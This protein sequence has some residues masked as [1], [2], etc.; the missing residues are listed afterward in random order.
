M[1]TTTHDWLHQEPAPGHRLLTYRGDT[2]NFTLTL[3]RALNGTA[4]LRTNIGYARITRNEIFRDVELDD[5]PL[6]R[7]WFD[8][9]MVRVDDHRFRIT[10]PLCEVGHFEAK[11]FFL[12]DGQ[13]HP[14]WPSGSNTEVNVEP[15]ATCCANIIYNAFVRQFGPNRS[16]SF[17]APVAPSDIRALD[18]AG[19]TVIPPSGTFRDLVAELDFIIGT[20]GCRF[21]QL[22]PIH[23]TP[24]TYGRMGR[25]GSPYAALS[26][27][28]VDPALARFDPAATPLEQFIELVDA[29]HARNAKILI[30]IAINHTGWA[31]GLHESHP[32]WLVRNNKGEIEVPGAWGVR[33]EDLTKLDYRH[34]D[35]WQYM[36]E[37]FLTWCRRGVDGFRCDAGYM[38]PEAA[39]TYI[40][41]R[42]REQFPDTIFL[43]E[44]LGGKISV[45]RRLLNRSNFNWAYSELF[46][47][48]DRKQIEHYL[49]ETLDLS[50]CDGVAVHYAETHDNP[51]LASRSPIYARMRTTLS[52]LLS[53]QGAFG[54]ANGVEWLAAEKINVHEASS[55]SWG[56]EPNQVAQIR[57]LSALLRTHPVFSHGT[58][59][60][61]I[62]QG[63]GNQVV[64]LRRHRPSGARLLI[65]VNLDD[66]RKVTAAWDAPAAGLGGPDLVDLLTGQPVTVTVANGRQSLLLEPGQ[67]LCLSDTD[68]DLGAIRDAPS[69]FFEMPERV[70]HQMLCAKA[71]DVYTHYFG[72]RHLDAF[73]PDAAAEGLHS[74]PEAF[75]RAVNPHSQESRVVTWQYPRD[76]RRE[77]MVPPGHFLLVRADRHFH[78]RITDD[79]RTLA[80]EESL[81]DA[82]GSHFALFAPPTEPAAVRV[83]HLQLV[84]H[85]S[86]RSRHVNGTLLFLPDAHGMRIKRL[87]RRRELLRAPFL[88]L[89]TNGRGAML[90]AAI[91]WGSLN[92]RYD[93]LLAANLSDDYPEDRRVLLTRCR[94]WLIYQGFS[95][96]VGDSCLTDF[97]VDADNAGSWHFHIPTGQGESVA[98]TLRAAMVPGRNAVRLVFHRPA[99]DGIP[100]RLAD[101]NPVQLILRPDIE[102]RNFHQT[103]KAYQ[104]P[105]GTWPAAVTPEADGFRFSPG[106]GVSLHLR[107]TDGHYQPEPEWH[108]MVH[109]PLEAERGLDPDSDLFSPGY[110][111][112]RLTGG[113]T[114][115]LS[116]DVGAAGNEAQTAAVAVPVAAD[117]LRD[118]AAALDAALSH[119][120]V[121]RGQLKSVVAGF[122]W[123]LDWGRDALI[124]TR[125]LIAAGRLAEARDVLQQFGRFEA[126]GT[127]PN[128]I[129]GED[130]GNR[131]TSD[132]PL[133]FFVACRDLVQKI[134]DAGFLDS[135]WNGRTPRDILLSMGC[136]LV[137]GTPNG[138]YMDPDSALLFSPAHF[139]WMD[140]DHPA[141][142]PREGFPIEIQA[143]W[144]AALGFLA[145]IDPADGGRRWDEL[146]TR[147]RRSII[148][149]YYRRQDGYFCD[150]LHAASGTP[151]RQ[152]DADDALRPNQLLALT[153]GAVADEEVGRRVL[154]ACESLLVPGAIRSLD[155]RPV[156]RPLP[157][158]LNGKVLNDAHHPYQGTYTGDE[159]T[160]RKVAYHNGTAWTWLFPSHCEAWFLFYGDGGRKAALD[161]LASGLRL[162]ESGCIGHIPEILDGNAPHRQR[163]CDAQAWGVSELLRVW[164]LLNEGGGE[165]STA[166]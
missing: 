153:L 17:N 89:A 76:V 145:A 24:T 85:M 61:L 72:V 73:D 125:G 94:V 31:A 84:L 79:H 121:R 157:V 151:A 39:W 77:V 37:M 56:A 81:P 152:A 124:F 70:R 97:T 69:R 102:N 22:L 66:T 62:Q 44:G 23:P 138:I 100:G 139:T 1:T 21:L 7:D 147:V 87:Y 9:P 12:P 133:W 41:A 92:S 5:P 15:A 119:Y 55:L 123:F 142:T 93:A 150:C 91:S 54:F 58:E 96:E 105:E 159:D 99:A 50:R 165:G 57:R 162:L 36:A 103:T 149:L 146:S 38:I 16:G 51:R 35:L 134:P 154:T 107:L 46:Q 43:L 20:L 131:D 164:L 26:F 52:A 126:D 137:G 13:S 29:V 64:L 111:S 48:Y 28:E 6:G 34:R 114:A 115:V 108:Y 118:P 132:A 53:H 3:G 59:D 101:T 143:L 158:T 116:A 45:T 65:V 78:V 144:Q 18:E 47:N 86:P 160:R 141:G 88:F 33:W 63:A 74:D 130:A 129:R 113:A 161:R 68:V 4:W 11:C 10:L 27:T 104:G 136:S 14:F 90:R 156:Q 140:T 19:Y 60:C 98:L 67:V 117:D 49:P 83:C 30:D 112:T 40:I 109:R 80:A 25:F 148:D 71:L 2:Q 95:Q 135:I 163:G 166:D 42:V 127:I 106:D 75:C 128:M 155:D 32:R 8:T 122:P 82:G 110:F 120:V